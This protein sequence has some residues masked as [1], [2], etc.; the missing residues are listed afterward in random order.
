[1]SIKLSTGMRNHLLSG[2]SF[3]GA[4]DGGL[5][6]IYSGTPPSGA[7]D[8]NA[9]N[10]LLCTVSIGG[11]GTG[12]NFEAA[13]VAGVLSKASAETWQGTNAAT[14]TA[15][16]FRWAESGGS[17]ASASTTEKRIQ[18]TIGVAGADLNLSSVSL[19][20]GAVQTVDFFNVT[21]P[22]SA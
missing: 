17:P 8:A 6:M 11:A 3:K 1:M 20:S 7:D 5:I 18:G 4:L 9:G 22:A 15:S 13:A 16:F 14:G 10:T 21:L 2:G 19:A 12:I